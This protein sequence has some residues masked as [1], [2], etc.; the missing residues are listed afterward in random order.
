MNNINNPLFYISE[1]VDGV[2]IDL[3]KTEPVQAPP[4]VISG[5]EPTVELEYNN[6]EEDLHLHLMR[7]PS[8]AFGFFSSPKTPKYASPRSFVGA[9][10]LKTEIQDRFH[11]L[12]QKVMP[13]LLIAHEYYYEEF[14]ALGL[15][16]SHLTTFKEKQK[17]FIRYSLHFFRGLL[18][19]PV[20]GQEKSKIPGEMFATAEKLRAILTDKQ[21]ELMTYLADENM[22]HLERNANPKILFL[23]LSI[24]FHQIMQNKISNI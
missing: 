4:H 6:N 15:L 11:Q 10:L 18:V 5:V 22:A 8:P 21:L 24:R 14:R 13:M 19:L 3:Q 2:L 9:K 23:D 17:I 20:L 1:F 12:E 16:I 7:P